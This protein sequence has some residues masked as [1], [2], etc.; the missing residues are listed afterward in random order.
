MASIACVRLGWPAS[1]FFDWS[2]NIS[3]QVLT[4]Y[5]YVKL[6]CTNIT[7]VN[8]TAWFEKEHGTKNPPKTIVGL[9]FWML[10]SVEKNISLTLSTS[11]QVIPHRNEIA[12]WVSR[13]FLLGWYVNEPALPQLRVEW[14]KGIDTTPK[15]RKIPS[16]SPCDKTFL[17]PSS[18]TKHDKKVA[19]PSPLGFSSFFCLCIFFVCSRAHKPNFIALTSSQQSKGKRIGDGV[20][21]RICSSIL[22]LQIWLLISSFS[23][24]FGKTFFSIQNTSSV[25]SNTNTISHTQ[26]RRHHQVTKA[27]QSKAASAEKEK[28]DTWNNDIMQQR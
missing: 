4:Y 9:L 17:L 5:T 1:L 22:F 23:F 3:V 2:I 12:Y 15:G 26:R 11:E 13:L 10:G 20:G 7:A 18:A 21:T 16:P 19:S 27:K 25:P 28:K 24:F 14:P 6:S 8:C